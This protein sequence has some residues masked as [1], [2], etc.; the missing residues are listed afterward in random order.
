MDY[1]TDM[2]AT[3]TPRNGIAELSEGELDAVAGGTTSGSYDIF[4]TLGFWIGEAA[5]WIGRT[6]ES[7]NDRYAQAVLQS[8]GALV[9]NM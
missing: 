4:Y 7:I 3:T 2:G 5:A 9:A 8:D 6:A 1:R